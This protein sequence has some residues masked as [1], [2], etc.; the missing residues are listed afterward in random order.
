MSDYALVYDEQ[1]GALTG[2]VRDG[3]EFVPRS[4]PAWADVVAWAAAQVPPVD[5]SDRAPPTEAERLAAARTAAVQAFL[6][7]NEP[8]IVAT[9]ALFRLAFTWIN[10]ERERRGAARILEPEIIAQAMG[11]TLYDG[12]GDAPAPP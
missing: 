7:S 1:T 12:L 2:A 8:V 11:G 10:D 6:T 9:R 4:A 3:T 5:L